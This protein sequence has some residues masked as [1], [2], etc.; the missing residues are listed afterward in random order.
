[1]SVLCYSSFASL[2]NAKENCYS[3]H[4]YSS[5]SWLL[6]ETNRTWKYNMGVFKKHLC[7]SRQGIFALLRN[8]LWLNV[9]QWASP[10]T[11]YHWSYIRYV[12]ILLMAVSSPGWKA[13]WVEI[14]VPQASQ[15]HSHTNTQ[16]SVT[17][18]FGWFLHRELLECWMETGLTWCKLKAMGSGKQ[19]WEML[20]QLGSTLSVLGVRTG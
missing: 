3:K 16:R 18:A 17:S 9:A 6:W 5:A 10:L 4:L 14:W 7:M 19:R 1:M 2:Y 12:F 11:V 15:V 20:C 8:T 13:G